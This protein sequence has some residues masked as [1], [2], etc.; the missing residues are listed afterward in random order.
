MC[1]GDNCT[2]EE[3]REILNE[4]FSEVPAGRFNIRACDLQ[5]EVDGTPA[6][7][8]T[9]IVRTQSQPFEYAGDP[10]MIADGFWVML[11]R[12]SA[13]EHEIMFA[14]AVCDIDTG[15]RLSVKATYFVTV[16]AGEG[17]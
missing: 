17:M 7:F 12:L 10:E 9:P 14:G 13:G 15:E 11:D 16:E 1:P 8:S 6:I 3:K 4:I 5:I 2:I